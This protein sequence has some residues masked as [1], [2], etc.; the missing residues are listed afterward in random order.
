MR[1]RLMS[2][3]YTLLSLVA[4]F[5]LAAVI[6]AVSG[7]DPW[8]S[9]QAMFVGAFGDLTAFGETIVKATPL[10]ISGLAVALGLRAGLFNIGV[11]GQL[12]VGA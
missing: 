3:V 11:E 9:F 7:E 12:L 1:H 4:A 10:A 8:Q 5:A 2:L 6:I